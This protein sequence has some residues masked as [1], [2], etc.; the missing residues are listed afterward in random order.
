MLTIYDSHHIRT[1]R[2]R[3]GRMACRTQT[4]LFMGQ[5]E[6]RRVCHAHLDLVN[7]QIRFAWLI[8]QWA[9]HQARIGFIKEK[10]V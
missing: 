5:A 3:K 10:Y 2:H 4:G 9:G 1:N 8:R 6:S 7:Q